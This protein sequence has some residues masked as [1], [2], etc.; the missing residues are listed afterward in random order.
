MMMVLPC[1]RQF[2]DDRHDA[3]HFGQAQAGKEFVQD[4]QFRLQGDGLGQLQP[5]E[6]SLGQ[7][8]GRLVGHVGVPFETDLLQQIQGH[9]VPVAVAA[10]GQLLAPGGNRGG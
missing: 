7:G 6:I 5:L 10:P 8:A 3:G 1:W 2:F 9:G 4:D